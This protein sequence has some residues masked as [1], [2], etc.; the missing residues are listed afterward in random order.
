M[1]LRYLSLALGLSGLLAACDQPPANT[2]STE[3]TTTVA[4]V[5]D[6]SP[7]L[8]TVNGA[9]IT[10]AVFELYQQQM[11][12]RAPGNPAAM[13][14]EAILNEVINLELARQ[15]GEKEGVGK[16]SKVQLQV[17]QQTRAV[18]AS[19]AIQRYMSTHPVSDEDLKK[20]YDEQVPKGNEYKARHI[21]V[22]EEDAAKK[23][24]A[25]LDK[26]ADFSE[27]AKKNSTGPSGKSGGEL[28]WFSPKQMVAPFS[29]AAASL[30]KGA[31][32]KEPVKTQFGWHIIIL[33]DSRATT[34]PPFEQVKPQLQAFVQKQ[35]VQ[36][37]ITNLRKDANIVM[38]TPPAAA[39]P[40]PEVTGQAA[41]AE[42]AESAE[43]AASAEPSDEKK[44]E[45]ESGKASESEQK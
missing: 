26:G 15:S 11:Q 40:E 5:T 45:T 21:L 31:Y 43:P 25:E 30:E 32:T 42:P 27:L 39:A 41:S 36:E 3:S 35:H 7:V 10:E 33:D 4:T 23:L 44:D 8:A 29:E 34:P 18:L 9:P 17:E 16:D 28:G 22:E 12:A 6:S 14:R 24:I 37:Y 19:A 13:D 20:I 38:T 2:K 1:K